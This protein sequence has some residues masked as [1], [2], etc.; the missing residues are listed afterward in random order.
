MGLENLMAWAST[1]ISLLTELCDGARVCD[2][3]RVRRFRSG[4][5]FRARAEGATGCGSQS[6]VPQTPPHGEAEGQKDYRPWLP[7]PGMLR[8]HE[9]VSRN[10]KLGRED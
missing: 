1:K 10:R 8:Q 3:Q 2:P 9:R 6:R 5:I 7:Q 4:Q